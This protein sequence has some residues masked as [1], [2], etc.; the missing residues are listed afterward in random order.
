VSSEKTTIKYTGAIPLP[1]ADEVLLSANI[2]EE[3]DGFAGVLTNAVVEFKVA[4]IDINGTETE[5][6]CK[7]VNS[8][9]SGNASLKLPLE[10]GLYKVMVSVVANDYYLAATDTKVIP[11]YNPN[12]GEVDGGGWFMFE[13]EKVNIAVSASYKENVPNGNVEMNFHNNKDKFQS[14][15]INWILA[16]KN[17]VEICGI[18]EMKQNNKTKSCTFKMQICDNGKD[19]LVTVYIW[20]GTNTDDTPLYKIQSAILKGGNMKVN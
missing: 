18:G 2:A 3:N 7:A 1:Y 14:K 5:I 13:N 17:T 11:V 8:D 4:K 16:S 20:E 10:V 15:E 6:Y 12:A 19:D 9:I